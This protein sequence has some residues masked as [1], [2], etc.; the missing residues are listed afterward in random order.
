MTDHS[1]EFM[2][3]G[4]AYNDK[5]PWIEITLPKEETVSK[6]VLYTKISMNGKPR[7]TGADIS[8]HDGKGFVK[9]NSDVSRNGSRIE[10]TFPSVKAKKIRLDGFKFT[11][12]EPRRA[13]TEIEVY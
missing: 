9:L 13:L 4:P 8:Y 5:K 12:G 11:P 10:I 3:W 6:V 7:L 1:S 2:I